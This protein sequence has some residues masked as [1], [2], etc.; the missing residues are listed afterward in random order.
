M[1]PV[2]NCLFLSLPVTGFHTLSSALLQ[3]FDACVHG[4]HRLEDLAL[5][6]FEVADCYGVSGAVVLHVVAPDVGLENN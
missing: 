2:G 4:V 6:L 1:H 5:V 3:G